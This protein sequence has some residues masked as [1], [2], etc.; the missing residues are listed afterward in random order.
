MAED[1]EKPERD[2]TDLGSGLRG[3]TMLE[4]LHVELPGPE[5][6]RRRGRQRTRNH[7]FAGASGVAAIA[8][9][10][11]VGGTALAGSHPG[12]VKPGT[13]TSVAT[14]RPSTTPTTTAPAPD[15]STALPVTTTT[16]AASDP[17]TTG[18]RTTSPITSTTTDGPAVSTSTAPAGLVS[19]VNG[20]GIGKAIVDT[21]TGSCFQ[22]DLHQLLTGSAADAWVA[23]HPN[24]TRLGNLAVVVDPDGPVLHCIPVAPNV[25]VTLTWVPPTGSLGSRPSTFTTL[26]KLLLNQLPLVSSAGY[27]LHDTHY[28]WH[29]DSAG[30][31][32]RLDAYYTS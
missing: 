12:T 7:A 2:E 30:S 26:R 19:A 3:R 4:R 6:A 31:I 32:D 9:V 24:W 5:A 14:P 8:A 1:F 28:T 29:L 16:P 25:A 15:T 17:V 20:F 27:W 18:S 22:A 13:S 21:A 23:G 11:I 10:A